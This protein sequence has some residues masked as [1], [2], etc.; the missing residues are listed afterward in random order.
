MSTLMAEKMSVCSRGAGFAFFRQQCLIHETN[1]VAYH[2][3]IDG[4]FGYW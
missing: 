3:D 1:L 4:D 2:G